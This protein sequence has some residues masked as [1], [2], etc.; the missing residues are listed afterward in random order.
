MVEVARE[1]G[2]TEGFEVIPEPHCRGVADKVRA[3]EGVSLLRETPRIVVVGIARDAEPHL[4]AVLSNMERISSL[5]GDCGFVVLE[6]DSTDRTK[7]IILR[8]GACRRNFVFLNKDG[9][10]KVAAR[11]VRLETARNAYVDLLRSHEV[12]RGFDYAVLMDMDDANVY[13]IDAERIVDA[14]EFLSGDERHAAVFANQIGYYY[15]LWA[16]RHPTLCPGD[17]WEEV[18]D[19]VRLHGVS[20][21]YAF[22]M[23]FAPRM[24][25]FPVDA[26]RIPVDSAFGGLG[27]YRL[28]YIL[29]NPHRY[30]GSKEKVTTSVD[31]RSTTWRIQTCEH[32]HF[33]AGIRSQGGELFID[34]ALVNGAYAGNLAV[35]KSAF[36]GMIAGGGAA[37]V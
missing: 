30:L 34:P 18:S 10:G 35:N 7:E 12:F 14:L 6:N 8:W 32:V 2:W 19:H 23:K 37:L 17:I 5:A 26:Q 27:I 16:L 31:G 20:D 13:P 24:A 21:D 33:H 1:G 28:R 36:R 4:P 9:L 29:E 3:S 22:D 15:D 25:S 11:T